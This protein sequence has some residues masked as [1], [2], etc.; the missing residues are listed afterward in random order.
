MIAPYIPIS[1][2][3]P[4][5][6]SDSVSNA[7]LPLANLDWCFSF[8]SASVIHPVTGKCWR[9]CAVLS[10]RKVLVKK[11]SEYEPNSGPLKFSLVC[12]LSW[13]SH[14]NYACIWALK[15][16]AYFKNIVSGISDIRKTTRNSSIFHFFQK[17]KKFWSCLM[18][19]FLRRS[20]TECWQLSGRK[21]IC[22]IFG[23]NLIGSQPL[24]TTYL[25]RS[26]V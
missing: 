17:V 20:D 8:C 12:I 16:S 23:R 10:P 15:L 14:P 4:F 5:P 19:G 1:W 9:A 24:K 11:G 3:C 26:V 18:S 25:C 21:L 22:E 7:V 6:C 13:W 2:L